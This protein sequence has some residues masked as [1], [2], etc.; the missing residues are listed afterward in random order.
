MLEPFGVGNREPV[1]AAQDVRLLQPPGRIKEK[2]VKLR[3]A[4]HNA[5]RLR[6]YDAVGW[7]MAEMVQQE[8]LV[9]GDLLAIAFTLE[10]NKNPEFGGIQLVLRDVGRMDRKLGAV[11]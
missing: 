10:E 7:R 4:D 9:V 8:A 11:R 6:P 5:A 3:V 1:F 2:H